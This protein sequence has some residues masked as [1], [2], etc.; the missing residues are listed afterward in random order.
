MSKKKWWLAGALGALSVV[1]AAGCSAVVRDAAARDE[2][3]GVVG[4]YALM[5]ADGPL[6][7]AR[8]GQALA[9]RLD[10]SAEQQA[11]ARAIL[12]KYRGELR[13]ANFQ[14][15]RDELLAIGLAPEVDRQKLTALIQ[16]RAAEFERKKPARLALAAE[17]RGVLTPAQRETLAELLAS[18]KPE[19]MAR[20]DALRA[21]VRAHAT[22]RFGLTAAQLAKVDA[23]HARVD[24]LRTDPRHDQV[25]LA[26]AGFVRTGDV[27][28]LSA[29]LPEVSQ[30]LPVA[31]IVDVAASLDQAQRRQ[32]ARQA[33]RFA[34]LRL[35]QR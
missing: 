4:G 26:A 1:V 9:A 29:A 23:L 17:L 28:A 2:A 21:R 34:A 14:A 27:G 16:A 20:V 11:Q 13:P 8:P 22:S 24:A 6:M 5:A 3:V 25:R 35:A 12:A 15:L 31:E 32:L 7:S 19:L 10:L 18:G 30:L 33:K